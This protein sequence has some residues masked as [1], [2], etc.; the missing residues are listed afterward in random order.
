MSF[1]LTHDSKN[2]KFYSPLKFNFSQINVV[3]LRLKLVSQWLVR[4][5]S[6][7]HNQL[8]LSVPI[9]CASS[10]VSGSLISNVSGMNRKST[11]DNKAAPKKRKNGNDSEYCA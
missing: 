2:Y 8:C 1:S 4:F 5:V 10:S 9:D 11:P 6:I 3:A 7:T